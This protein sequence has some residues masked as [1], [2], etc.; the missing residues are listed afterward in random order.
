MQAN[1]P[2]RTNIRLQ[3]GSHETGICENQNAAMKSCSP[4]QMMRLAGLPFSRCGYMAEIGFR[5]F[6]PYVFRGF[7]RSGRSTAIKPIASRRN[8]RSYKTQ[9]IPLWAPMKPDVCRAS[10]PHFSLIHWPTPSS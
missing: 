9:A 1:S 10:F 3:A 6:P 5:R 7:C 8:R 2:F 4:E